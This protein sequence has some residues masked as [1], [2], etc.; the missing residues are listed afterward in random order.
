MPDISDEIREQFKHV[1]M[2]ANLGIK[3]SAVLHDF[4]SGL[5]TLHQ[6]LS[7]YYDPPYRQVVS[8]VKVYSDRVYLYDDESRYLDVAHSISLYW[9]R[10]IS[11]L[12]GRK[13]M[14]TG[15]RTVVSEDYVG[16]HPEF[17]NPNFADDKG[18][19]GE[20]GDE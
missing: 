3:N 11:A 15:N 1:R 8:E 12:L 10:A 9:F 4:Q 7:D 20:K 19:S 13:G 16:E 17:E 18:S 6:M 5:L 14:I 2:L